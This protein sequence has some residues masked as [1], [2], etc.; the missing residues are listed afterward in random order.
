MRAPTNRPIVVL[1]SVNMD[2]VLRCE[3]LPA[4]GETVHG[5]GF[6]RWPGGKGANQA[7]AAA[8]LG[9]RVAFLGC[10]GDDEFGR[11]ATAALQAEG[12]DVTGLR[13]VAGTSTG[14]A[15]ITVDAAGRNAIA[16]S[17]GANHAVSPAQVEAAADTL[18]GAALLVCQL[19]VPLAAVERAVALAHAAGVPVLLNPAPAAA[20]PASLLQ[21]VSLLVPNE[22]EA[23]LLHPRCAGA[24]DAAALLRTLGPATVVVTLGERGVQ[25]ADATGSWSA[26]A[27][28]VVAHDTTGAGDTFVG[29]LAVALTEGQ[30]LRD[31]VCFA[32][33]AAAISVTRAGAMPSM[34]R[35]G[36]LSVLPEA[37]A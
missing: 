20:L 17:G 1:G 25:V 3:R 13:S 32:Q 16:L 12:V 19:E 24:P 2:L 15:M 4:P 36:E 18:R 27:P 30:P 26:A 28:Q 9:G 10:V 11:E 8:R 22:S 34:P 35:R 29:A 33:Q 31:A 37:A 5:S 6:Q 7:V 14:V 21:Q 23:A